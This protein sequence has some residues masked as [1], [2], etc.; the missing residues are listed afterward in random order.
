[1]PAFD[2]RSAKA[3]AAEGERSSVSEPGTQS[4]PSRSSP[5]GTAS[6]PASL[7]SVSIL[8]AG[9][10]RFDHLPLDPARVLVFGGTES[11]PP[12]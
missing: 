8:A 5:G 7:I 11:A 2:N 3:I 9:V 1:M 6:A 4:I 12:T 10:L